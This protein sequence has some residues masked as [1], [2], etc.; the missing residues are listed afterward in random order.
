MVRSC[1]ECQQAQPLPAP[2]PLKPW[3]WPTR[4]WSRLHIDF[5]GPMDGRMFLVVVDAHSKWLDVIPM[6][7]TNAVTTI[8]QLRTLFSRFGVPESIV[9]DN[10]PQFASAEFRRFCELNG[11]RHFL[12]APYHPAS[13]GLAERGVQT[14]KRG[15]QKLKEGT[16]ED[17]IARFL[18]QYRV[19]PH[20]T[21]GRP[22][23]ELL[24]GRN[25]R[26]RLDVIKPDAGKTVEAKQFQQKAQYDRKSREKFFAVGDKVYA[27]NFGCGKPRL[28]GYL[29]RNAGPQS[30]MVK[31]YDGR[32]IRRHRNHLRS[33]V[34]EKLDT[35]LSETSSD[36]D[37][38][39]F[40]PFPSSDDSQTPQGSNSSENQEGQDFERR[41]PSRTRR[42][43]ERYGT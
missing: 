38:F 39:T 14:F 30:G 33:R 28:L 2:A 31:L 19:T 41:Y 6:K 12:I 17:R 23:A 40:G 35:P 7:T 3:S 36:S 20:T 18:L 16:V 15:Y 5:A 24:F 27:C 13:N 32:V 22:P 8:Q 43:P 25:L 11:I 9:S 42:P 21:T 29:L 4:P 34:P 26:T 1:S 10:G 37:D